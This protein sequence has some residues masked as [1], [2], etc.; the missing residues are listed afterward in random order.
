MAGY[1]YNTSF[2]LKLIILFWSYCWIPSD[3][4]ILKCATVGRPLTLVSGADEVI[5]YVNTNTWLFARRIIIP[6]RY[7]T[8]S[9]KA[10][11]MEGSYVKANSIHHSYQR[12]CTTHD[13]W[14]WEVKYMIILF[15]ISSDLIRIYSTLPSGSWQ[16]GVRCT[17]TY[18]FRR[19]WSGT[20]KLHHG[21][22][23]YSEL[24]RTL[25]SKLL[26]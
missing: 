22:S 11:S 3:M 6:G 4:R 12:A 24:H 10:G 8:H 14:N 20:W 9:H 1:W 25:F 5:L 26:H 13:T 18:I 23:W 15:D 21:K 16:R 17:R 7:C 19:K 2:C